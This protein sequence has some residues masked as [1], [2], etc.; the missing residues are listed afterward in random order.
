MLQH[1][2]FGA[3]NADLHDIG[4]DMMQDLTLFEDYASDWAAACKATGISSNLNV[5]GFIDGKVHE[6][7]RNG[8]FDQQRLTYNGNHGFNGF[9]YM[10]CWA[11]CGLSIFTSGAVEGRRH[12]S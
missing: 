11:P 5:I 12:D 6:T 10:H 8:G 9:S 4:L 2:V 3:M 7:C 1:E